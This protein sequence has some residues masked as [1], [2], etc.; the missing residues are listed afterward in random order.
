MAVRVSGAGGEGADMAT[1]MTASWR[2]TRR[3]VTKHAAVLE[4][5][6][7]KDSLATDNTWR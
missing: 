2:V 1:L 4:F 6:W 3:S 5:R 7:L